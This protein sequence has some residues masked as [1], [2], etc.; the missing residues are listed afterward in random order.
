MSAPLVH[1]APP[2]ALHIRAVAVAFRL[3]PQEKGAI[4][5]AAPFVDSEFARVSPAS[6][7]IIDREGERPGLAGLVVRLSN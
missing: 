6:V 4:L 7:E 2:T 1:S 3:P 5:P